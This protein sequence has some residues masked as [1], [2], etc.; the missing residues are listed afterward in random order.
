[1]FTFS[2]E[3][4][5][6]HEPNFKWTWEN[7]LFPHFYFKKF[8]VCL[9]AIQFARGLNQRQVCEQIKISSTTHTNIWNRLSPP[10][11]HQF[12][13]LSNWMKLKAEL[14]FPPYPKA[15]ITFVMD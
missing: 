7:I 2:F 14:F 4:K 6:F 13:L 12:I 5:L 8:S 10:N 15:E 1:M 3:E 11:H 9:Y